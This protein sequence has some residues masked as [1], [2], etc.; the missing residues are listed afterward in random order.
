MAT[1]KELRKQHP[2][3]KA[4]SV[5]KFMEKL[6]KGTTIQADDVFEPSKG[7]GDTIEKIIPKVVKK[8]VEWIAGK[9]CG[10]Q[11]RKNTLNELY[12]YK[13][14]CMLESEF[15]WWTEY[16]RQP[17]KAVVVKEDVFEISKIFTRLFNQKAAICRNCGSKRI[18]EVIGHINKVYESYKT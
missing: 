18:L 15:I 17:Y 11:E 9:D 5:K 2:E 12:S 3:I 7:L 16:L 6:N 4:T 14:E 1:L 8:A 13:V 10:C